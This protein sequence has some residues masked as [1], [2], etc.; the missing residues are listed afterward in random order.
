MAAQL[1]NPSSVIAELE[2]FDQDS[3]G[4]LE[5]LLFKNRPLILFLCLLAT[6]FLGFEATKTKLNAS[7]EKMIPTEQ[8]FIVNFLRH[9]QDL[10]GQGNAINIVV[11]ANN[12]NIIDAHYL[13][14]LQRINDKVFLLPG[15]D[16]PFMTSLWTPST[17]WR[18]VT[19]DGMAGGPVMGAS[20]DGSPAQLSIVRQNIEET[21]QV[22][23]LVSGDFSSSVIYAPLMST[24]N[25]T[26]KP[27]DY[28]ALARQL[29]A[30]RLE[31]ASQ[32]VTLHIVG[33]AMVVGEMING[34]DKILLFFGVSILFAAGMLFW[35][36]RCAR[37]TLL[38]VAAS[39]IAVTWQM[40]LIPL[41][42]FDL[43]PYSVLVPFLVFA[44]GMSHGAQ[45]MNGVMQ[46]IGRG[47]HPLIAA[48]Y[49]FRRLFLA[50]FAALTCDAVSFAVLMTIHIEAIRELAMI[51]SLG[52][53]ILIF[54]NLIMLPMLLSYTGVNRQAALRSL[55]A[56][57]ATAGQQRAHPMWRFLDLFTQ[58]RYARIAIAAAL[59]LGIVGWA[60]GRNVQVGDLNQGAPELRQN[61]QYNLDNAYFLQHY[62]S[63]SDTFVVL[64]DTP[65]G[66]CFSIDTLAVMDDLGWRLA[67]LPQVQ[68]AYS[69]ASFAKMMTMFDTEDSPKWDALVNQGSIDDFSQFIPFSLVDQSCSFMPIYVALT[70]HK[71]TT[72]DTVVN[73]VQSFAADK[74]NQGGDFKISLAGGNAGIAAA[75]NI[76][77]RNANR[78]M[79][80]LVYAAVIIF[81]FITFKSW[82]A[83]LCAVLPLI[84]TS[85]LSQALMVWL[86][87]GIKVAT[88][89]VIALGVGI[90]VD[91]ALYVLSITL[92][93]LREGAT[94][95]HA[96]YRTLLFTGKVVLLT[97]F[98]LAAGV[99]TWVLAPIKFQADMGL[100]L[101][102]MFI[103]N[104]LGALILLPA[105]ACFLLP[106][107]LFR[108][109]AEA[110]GARPCAAPKPD[111]YHRIVPEVQT[112]P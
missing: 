95:S 75:T 34:I 37:S 103:W 65:P 57:A 97:G 79:L 111:A 51:A 106:E 25:L 47:T 8:P 35:Y 62:E 14:V 92:K 83:V 90:G 17:R 48:R 99:A 41:L 6:L 46:D 5:G 26:G 59:G 68:S 2:N 38:V 49:T 101:S 63:G 82:R 73:A 12:G 89:P 81:C 91:Y 36:T 22:G 110:A 19:A 61:S 40:G 11:Q 30:L 72:L 96:Y 15:V 109:P 70:D 4:F 32:G 88:L 100:L 105:L 84:L 86:G 10:Q 76:V 108:Q 39:L 107:R 67:Q 20:Y 77:I 52:V 23:Q 93:Q 64:V 3:G 16:R 50:G 45:K 44:I 98:T 112:L 1:P 24:N 7:F 13:A 78:Q 31:Y 9:Y 80:Y 42:G 85:I 74:A 60:A 33:F 29:N 54:T 27:L 43:N 21:G 87:I 55:H 58:R 104:M 18:T 66:A 69:S 56:E 94:L 102:F 28:G 71:S 53:A